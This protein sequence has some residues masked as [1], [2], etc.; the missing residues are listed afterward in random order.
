M[1]RGVRN[2]M[3]D[4]RFDD[5][6]KA[7]A[8]RRNRRD[9]LKRLLGLGVAAGAAVVGTGTADAARRGFSGPKVPCT[10]TC[11][12]DSCGASDG[13]GDVCTSCSDG[14]ICLENGTCAEPC[15]VDADCS[16]CLICEL[17]SDGTGS[18]CGEF[19]TTIDCDS[20]ADCP[21][22][23]VCSAVASTCTDVCV[24]F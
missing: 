10:P 24:A 19:R 22:G 18:F 17:T 12:P 23:S 21:T 5:V 3:D 9:V 16:P 4:D 1:A 15:A 7:F 2:R 8:A 6:A 11:G 20:T 13:C 14:K